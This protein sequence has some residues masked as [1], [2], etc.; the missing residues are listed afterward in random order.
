MILDSA[1]KTMSP[2]SPTPNT[3]SQYLNEENLKH[4]ERIHECVK[5]NFGAFF[6]QMLQDNGV[7]Q[8]THSL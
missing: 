3:Y 6:N 2:S 1:K 7:E 4:L 8:I 5:L